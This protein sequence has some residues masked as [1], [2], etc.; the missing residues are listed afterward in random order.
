MYIHQK[1]VSE[2]KKR[3]YKLETRENLYNKT[4][5]SLFNHTLW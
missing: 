5:S 4:V 1:Q 2:Q 3:F